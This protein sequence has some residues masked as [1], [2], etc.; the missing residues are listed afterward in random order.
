MPHVSVAAITRAAYFLLTLKGAT[1]LFLSGLK[2]T[3]NPAMR[4][5]VAKATKSANKVFF[6]CDAEQKEGSRVRFDRS[7]PGT[8]LHFLFS[9]ASAVTLVPCPPLHVVPP[10]ARKHLPISPLPPGL[11]GL[12]PLCCH[13]TQ[14]SVA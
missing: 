5:I 2:A 10:L 8:L 1:A 3:I 4:P 7:T 14:G 6:L 11:S 9:Q 13:G 12:G